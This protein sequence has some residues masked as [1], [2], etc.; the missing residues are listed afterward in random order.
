MYALNFGKQKT[1]LGL[2]KK[3]KGILDLHKRHDLGVP[4]KYSRKIS[5]LP[6]LWNILAEVWT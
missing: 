4:T 5:G 1:F 2:S 6:S 3:C